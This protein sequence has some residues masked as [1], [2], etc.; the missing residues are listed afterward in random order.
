MG[1]RNNN[2]T[3]V[4]IR[5]MLRCA[6]HIDQGR[7]PK[8]GNAGLRWPSGPREKGLHTLLRRSPMKEMRVLP[9]VSRQ[10][11]LR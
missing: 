2:T 1:G 10:G 4:I 9:A 8:G 3:H 7:L 6:F 5:R 11:V